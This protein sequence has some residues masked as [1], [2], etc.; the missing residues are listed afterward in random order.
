MTDVAL[1][2]D[3]FDFLSV[4]CMFG[5]YSLFSFLFSSCEAGFGVFQIEL[6]PFFLR[7]LYVFSSSFCFLFSLSLSLWILPHI[8]YLFSFFFLSVDTCHF[9]YVYVV[10]SFVG[11]FSKDQ[12]MTFLSLFG[13]NENQVIMWGRG[14]LT[15][16]RSLIAASLDRRLSDLES[17]SPLLVPHPCTDD[18]RLLITALKVAT[19]DIR[20][21]TFILFLSR[22]NTSFLNEFCSSKSVDYDLLENDSL[23]LTLLDL[24]FWRDINSPLN[25]KTSATLLLGIISAVFALSERGTRKESLA[26]LSDTVSI[27]GRCVISNYFCRVILCFCIAALLTNYGSFSAFICC[28]S[29]VS[30]LFSVDPKLYDSRTDLTVSFI[31][32]FSPCLMFISHNFFCT[33]LQIF[34]DFDEYWNILSLSR[35][36]WLHFDSP[37]FC[38]PWWT[39]WTSSFG[40]VQWMAASCPRGLFDVFIYYRTRSMSISS[41][42]VLLFV[43]LFS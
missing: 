32:L 11:A 38:F 10:H 27:A 23:C 28:T 30:V 2:F 31:S 4:F 19:S 21:R 26:I 13:R 8:C 34:D 20:F 7:Y 5:L 39:E 18:S 1:S 3:H 17:I 25:V 35:M 43:V 14:I 33:I 9:L 40:S 29:V 37:R 15:V 6:W 41:H 36:V 22:G 42:L 24:P 12:C 16:F